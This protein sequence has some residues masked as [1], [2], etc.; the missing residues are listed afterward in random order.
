MK[1]LEENGFFIL[2]NFAN[3]NT[4]ANLNQEFDYLIKNSSL[5]NRSVLT[6][7]KSFF[8]Y[9]KVI[10][11]AGC[12]FMKT[13]LFEI[14]IEIIDLINKNTFNKGKNLI[15]SQIW[16]E[17]L[18]EPRKLFW[19]N[20]CMDYQAD[21]FRAILHLNNLCV[22]NGP[23]T[24]WPSSHKKSSPKN[25]PHALVQSLV[26]DAEKNKLFC[27]SNAGD[28]LIFDSR[29]I[30]GRA[31]NCSK[32]PNKTITFEFLSK[33][34]EKRIFSFTLP[35]YHMSNKVL[36]NINYFANPI[37]FKSFQPTDKVAKYIWSAQHELNTKGIR[38]ISISM[39]N[40]F[41]LLKS[42]KIFNFFKINA[43]ALKNKFS[44]GRRKNNI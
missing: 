34:H 11:D 40:I 38:Y 37:N 6:I 19:H 16:G 5:S 33:S 43:S 27:E 10:A 25:V 39:K 29:L 4:L 2:R 17:Y 14:A 42:S 44:P 23:L 24:I 3:K 13:N 15:V 9:Q 30:H 41:L 31:S 26:K 12:V 32:E 20:D 21:H 18:L 7:Y 1:N 22:D 35:P 36:K 8:S 28:L